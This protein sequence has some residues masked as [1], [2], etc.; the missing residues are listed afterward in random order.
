MAAT[1]TAVLEFIANTFVSFP[2]REL[3]LQ[4]T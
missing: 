1:D 3:L 2:A 4:T